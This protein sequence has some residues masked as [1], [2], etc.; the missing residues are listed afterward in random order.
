MPE[1]IRVWHPDPSGRA[2]FDLHTLNEYMD[3]LRVPSTR[4]HFKGRPGGAGSSMMRKALKIARVLSKQQAGDPIDVVVLV[5]DMDQQP[6]DRRAGVTLARDEARSW[7][8]FEIVCGF[9]DPEREAWV[10]AGFEPRDEAERARLAELQDALGF[11]PV[12]HAVR[13]RD[14]AAGAA[15]NI[16][17]V[18]GQLTR[19]DPDRE[20]RCWTE[21]PLEIL[22]ERGEPSGLKDF[23]DEIE[24]AL[25]PLLDPSGAAAPS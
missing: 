13:L 19:D 15:R 18:L 1:V 25:L 21:P 8:D 20:E 2:Y 16:K 12:E 10:L 24:R 14:K 7:T 22:R 23:L 3:R 6:D 11:S 5:W 9:Q 17:R 4:G